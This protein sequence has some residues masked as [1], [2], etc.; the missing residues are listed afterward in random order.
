MDEEEKIES[1]NLKQSAGYIK[2]YRSSLEKKWLRNHKLWAFWTWCLL[3]A[4]WKKEK[5]VI[6]FREV[7]LL[8]G[9]FIMGRI[10]AARELNISEQG[11]RTCLKFLKTAKNLTIQSTNRFSIVTIINWHVYQGDK[12]QINHQNNTPPPRCPPAAHQLPT[13]YKKEKNTKIQ[14]LKNKYPCVLCAEKKAL[15]EDFY[16]RFLNRAEHP[17]LFFEV[18]ENDD[19][20]D[21]IADLN[22]TELTPPTKDDTLCFDCFKREMNLKG[23]KDTSIRKVEDALWNFFDRTEGQQPY[24]NIPEWWNV[25]A[26]GKE[27]SLIN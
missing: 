18:N 3:K 5:A 6:N 13:T 27:L 17:D 26:G 2:L 4:K 7:E 1:T 22:A 14:E 15:E 24:F 10:N 16:L 9:Q 20:Y 11:I 19:D 21:Y 23:G 25:I 8:P 12:A